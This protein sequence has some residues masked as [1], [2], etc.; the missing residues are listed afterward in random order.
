MTTNTTTPDTPP[1][2]ATPRRRGVNLW[3]SIITTLTTA[4]ITYQI[5]FQAGTTTATTQARSTAQALQEQLE[6]ATQRADF[7]AHL[8]PLY[9]R[10]EI[11]GALQ[12]AAAATPGATQH[13]DVIPYHLTIYTAGC[14]PFGNTYLITLTGP[15]RHYERAALLHLAAQETQTPSC[16]NTTTI[17]LFDNHITEIQAITLLQQNQ[18]PAPLATAYIHHTPTQYTLTTPQGSNPL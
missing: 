2:P 16:D 17:Y 18:D 9:K 5:G 7:Y 14:T 4:A 3:L 6:Q 10:S 11:L 15:T 12:A 1:A 13:Y 8:A